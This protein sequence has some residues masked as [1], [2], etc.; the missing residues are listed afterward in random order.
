MVTYW[1]WIVIIVVLLAL[2]RILRSAWFR[3]KLGEFKVNLALRLLLRRKKYHLK[4]NVTLP[5]PGGTTQIDHLVVSPYGVFV[6]ETKNLRG[7]IFGQPNQPKWT[8]VFFK[9]KQSFQNPLHQ[10]HTHVK[11]VRGLLGLGADRLHNVVV[12]VGPSTFKTPMPPEVLQGVFRLV[13]YIRSKR[14]V[15]FT[16]EQ[17]HHFLAAIEMKRLGPGFRTDRD[18]VRNL[19]DKRF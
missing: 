17:I 15:V 12:F 19:T 9:F 6:I 11:A 14:D 4:K 16:D 2:P 3:G 7:W 10:N 13:R 1:H 8:Q 18:H 5:I